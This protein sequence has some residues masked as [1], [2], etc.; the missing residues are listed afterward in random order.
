[1][2][3]VT[4]LLHDVQGNLKYDH[5]VYLH[6]RSTRHPVG[7]VLTFAHELQHVSQH[8]EDP[9]M[10][11]VC[12]LMKKERRFLRKGYI[13]LPHEKDAMFNSRRIA[14]ALFGRSE[15]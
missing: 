9:E 4:A 14:E 6:A 15:V 13:N 10:L 5:L 2:V 12:A 11:R 7:C 1:P 8:L 3:M